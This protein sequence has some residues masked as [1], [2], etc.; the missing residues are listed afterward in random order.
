MSALREPPAPDEDHFARDIGGTILGQGTL[1]PADPEDHLTIVTR[2][3]AAERV[4]RELLQQ[5]VTAARGSG[6]SWAAIGNEL[7]LSRQAVQ[8]RFG[9]R[10]EA[11]THD[12]AE[13]ARYR[14]LGPVTA[15]EEMRELEIAGR[16]G[17]HTVEAGMLRHKVVRTNTQWEHKRIVWSGSLR[18][19][20]QDGWQV[21]CRAFPWV[22]LVRDLGTPPDPEA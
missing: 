21:G 22:Y 12:P 6:H 15:F 5:A 17:W 19:L 7:G 16:L 20:E 18:R 1:N 11:A 10:A 14:W 2:S 13:D 4:T 3:A 9:G 8:Q